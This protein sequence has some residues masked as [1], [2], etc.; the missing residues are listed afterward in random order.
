MKK[1]REEFGPIPKEV[2]EASQTLKKAGFEAYL[3]GGCVRDIILGIA[4][5]DWDITTD[6]KPEQIIAA[7]PKTFYENTFGTVGVV[8]ENTTDEI[9]KVIEITPYR[10]EAEYSDNRRPDAVIF[11]EK[12]DDDLHRRDFTINA[13]ALNITEEGSK[14]GFYK[15]NIED[16]YGGQEDL[17]K[18]VLKIRY[19]YQYVKISSTKI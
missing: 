1:T 10:L 15:G 4:P 18:K 5:K 2:W 11:S 3:I 19:R 14:E 6:A 7:F 9:V 17:K 12:L 8:N 16:Y 13:I